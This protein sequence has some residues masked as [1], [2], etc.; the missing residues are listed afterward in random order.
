MGKEE[1]VKK[2]DSSEQI[3]IIESIERLAKDCGYTWY[4]GQHPDEQISAL[5]TAFTELKMLKKAL[6]APK[7]L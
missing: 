2:I 4:K 3:K 1:L 7:E 6:P 5:L